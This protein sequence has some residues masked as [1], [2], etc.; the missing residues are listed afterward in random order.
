MTEFKNGN[1]NLCSLPVVSWIL[2]TNSLGDHLRLTIDSCLQQTFPDFELVI[3]ANGNQ[4]DDIVSAI[5]FW[6]GGDT[7]VRVFSTKVRHLIFSLSL[8]LH[9][10]RGE[11]IARIDADD[12]ALVNRL[13]LQINFF[14]IYP[15]TSVLGGAYAVI[16]RNGKPIREVSLPLTNKEIRKALPFRNPLCHPSVMFRREKI[17]SVGGYFGGVF[18]EDYDLWVRL[19]NDPKIIFSNL[20][21]LLIG[22]R[23]IGQEARGN[24]VA[25][26]SQASIQF[27]NFIMGY[28]YYWLLGSIFSCCKLIIK[29][30]TYK[31]LQK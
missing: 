13:E 6:F 27:R 12:L 25:Y 14:N 19:S 17:L 28:G 20:P 18:C 1:I 4:S 16:D 15:E 22:Y 24:L 11:Y 31:L 7:R 5:K 10:A 29:K 2:C 3:V 21:D 30:L 23:E 9:Y 26:C 8:G